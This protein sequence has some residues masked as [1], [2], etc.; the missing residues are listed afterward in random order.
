M[1]VKP[2]EKRFSDDRIRRSISRILRENVLY[3][4]S[5]VAPGN[6]PH[7]NTAYFSYTPELGL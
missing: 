7:V 1:T 2:L 6:R 3:S 4:M 5:T